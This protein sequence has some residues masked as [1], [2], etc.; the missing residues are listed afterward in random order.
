[1]E[2]AIL[3]LIHATADGKIH[4]ED[5]QYNREYWRE[6]VAAENT[7]L[8]YWEW[9]LHMYEANEEK[10]PGKELKIF[11]VVV[12]AYVDYALQ[13]S[14]YEESD[15]RDFAATLIDEGMRTHGGGGAVSLSIDG[16]EEGP[17]GANLR[18]VWNEAEIREIGCHEVL[19]ADLSEEDDA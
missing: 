13:V 7:Q 4:G 8:G 17:S 14:A 1:M 6:E 15:A 10:V 9:V 18:E 3:D 16:S 2:Q 5:L 19:S 12:K 11:D